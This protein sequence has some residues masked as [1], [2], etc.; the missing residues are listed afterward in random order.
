MN[1]VKR[2]LHRLHAYLLEIE[3][4]PEPIARGLA[5][6]ILAGLTPFWGM[7]TILALLLAL[8]F[9][10]DKVTALLASWLNN[11]FTAPFIHYAEFK[12]GQKLL[13]MLDIHVIIPGWSPFSAK[14]LL[15]VGISILVAVTVGGFILGGI[16]A[17]AIYYF[18]RNS[19]CLL[20]LRSALARLSR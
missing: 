2:L 16:L 9:K 13:G 4:E 8:R 17:P 18:L 11:F 15:S 10:G 20:N 12:M 7:H 5:L 3:G 6:G 14:A 1:W 19:S